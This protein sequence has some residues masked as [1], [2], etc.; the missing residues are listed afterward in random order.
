M[1]DFDEVLITI[2]L[3]KTHYVEPEDADDN[4][5][6]KKAVYHKVAK[7]TKDCMI[8]EIHSLKDIMKYKFEKLLEQMERMK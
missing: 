1:S 2:T 4:G 7:L 5:I 6:R 3:N 8:T